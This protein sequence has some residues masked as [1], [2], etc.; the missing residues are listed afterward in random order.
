MSFTVD[1]LYENFSQISSENISAVDKELAFKNII[2]A[3]TGEGNETKL[4]CQFICRLFSSFPACKD[5]ALNA[6]RQLLK[7]SSPDI[8]KQA[9]H[10]LPV[11]TKQYPEKIAYVTNGMLELL[12]TEDHVELTL[13]H[14]TLLTLINQC[15]NDCLDAIFT[16]ID[17]AVDSFIKKRIIGFI[18]TKSQHLIENSKFTDEVQTVIFKRAKESLLKSDSECFIGLVQFIQK[19]PA[20]QTLLARQDIIKCIIDRAQLDNHVDIQ[21]TSRL[22]FLLSCI[23]HSLHL[24]SRNANSTAFTIFVIDELCPNI[25]GSHWT[26]DERL[27]ILRLLAALMVHCGKIEEDHDKRHEIVFE[28]LEHY[29]HPPPEDPEAAVDPNFEL[30]ALECVL[31][32]YHSICK[33]NPEYLMR[34]EVSNEQFKKFRVKLQYLGQAVQ[35]YIKQLKHQNYT[36]T[37]DKDD[38]IRYTSLTICTNI[39]S[40]IRDFFHNPPSFK[41]NIEF[42][43]I[44]NKAEKRSSDANTSNESSA[45][46]FARPERSIYQPNRVRKQRAKFAETPEMINRRQRFLNE[47]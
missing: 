26:V 10:D 29:L 35:H 41:A 39:H 28:L 5:Q 18:L 16:S 13:I 36:N 8:R 27:Q 31:Y 45:K 37:D 46:R 43:W 24:Y 47:Q 40:M 12:A 42:S 38:N 15:S 30:S 3:A 32:T 1:E 6:V 17:R 7:S 14:K 44:A 19:L 23:Q 34:N 25:I 4:A 9:I 20:C 33:M 11:L 21:D 2:Q 22:V